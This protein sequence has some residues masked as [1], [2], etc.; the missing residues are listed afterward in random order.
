MGYI[1]RVAE[2]AVNKFDKTMTEAIA[3]YSS[4]LVPGSENFNIEK[5]ILRDMAEVALESLFEE[6]G[7]DSDSALDWIDDYVPFLRELGL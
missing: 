3:E 4:A 2:E 5:E 7:G 6:F 1:K